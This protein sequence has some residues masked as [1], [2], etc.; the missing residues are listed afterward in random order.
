MIWRWMDSGR[1]DRGSI[2]PAVPIVGLV[3]LLLGG[4]VID[5]SRQL[6]ARG[7]AVAFAEEAARAGGQA[8]VLNDRGEVQL[9]AD[10]VPGLVADYCAIVLASPVVTRCEFVRIEP[11]PE[12]TPRPFTVV[13]EV[14]MQIPASLLGMVGVTN[15]TAS[16]SGRAEPAEGEI[17]VIS[18]AP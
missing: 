11:A 1:S 2:A 18:P 15:L 16:G 17:D 6:N 4:L 5:A 13:A 7:E 3:L 14:D 12:G 8:I 9:I 10:E